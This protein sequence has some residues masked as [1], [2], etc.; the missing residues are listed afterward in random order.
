MAKQISHN[1]CVYVYLS[2]K[3]PPL[4]YGCYRFPCFYS[5]SITET[6]RVFNSL[7]FTKNGCKIIDF[8]IFSSWSA[9]LRPTIIALVIINILIIKKVF[10]QTQ[11][12]E[13][14]VLSLLLWYQSESSPFFFLFSNTFSHSVQENFQFLYT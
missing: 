10:H 14:Q 2:E 7:C 9:P 5:I 6:V 3:A 11:K 4:S 12:K 1:L 8:R 13:E